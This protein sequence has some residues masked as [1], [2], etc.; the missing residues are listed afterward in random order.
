MQ[1]H[2]KLL[3]ILT[4]WLLCHSFLF[5]QE[6]VLDDK[7]TPPSFK[8]N[9]AE[10]H[11]DYLKNPETNPYQEAFGDELKYIS[12]NNS[13][14]SYLTIGAGYRAR[15]ENFVNQNWTKGDDSYY[16]QRLSIHTNWH[17]S[18]N[19]RIFGE[20]YHGLTTEKKRTLEDEEIDLHQGFMEIFA[21]NKKDNT[22]SL[23][24]GRQELSFGASRLFGIREGPNMRRSFDLARIIRKKGKRTF[25]AF[26][27][28]EV[29]PMFFAF[30]NESNIFGDAQVTNPQT[31]G[32][33]LQ[34]P[35]FVKD[36]QLD[37]YYIGF[38]NQSATFNDVT[39]EE[40]RH[41][42]GL[43][44]SG[45]PSIFSFNTELIYQ[46]GN[47]GGSAIS[48]FN[49]EVDY[50]IRISKGKW[51]PMIGL[52]LDWSSGDVEAGDGKIQTFNPLFVNP[53][54]YSLA[55]V[56]TPANL[57]S[58]HPSFTFFPHPKLY[59]YIEYA[60][61]YRTQQNDGFYSPPRFLTRPAQSNASRH[62]GD[63]FG[64]QMIWSINRN[65]QYQ[66]MSTYFLAADYIEA[67]GPSN[68][69]FYFSTTLNFRI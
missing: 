21:I 61:F 40:T 17:F 4:I 49:F 69:I 58:I 8:T 59:C 43:R 20:W 62:I 56:N 24:L 46:F 67:S 32:L 53:A 33:Y 52:K 18:D 26:Y 41:T 1:A 34:G 15:W 7:P 27:G 9:R 47:I 55:G 51:K 5:A 65:I 42:V 64:L 44:S 12:L 28:R 6:M 13:N 31:W 60:F 11:Y 23:H 36:A 37:F 39:G 50:K 45:T 54:I 22:L 57:T 48:A 29:N 68:N 30:D 2:F 63:T 14:T 35:S 66:L 25:H 16:S 10:E 3:Q 19:I 38:Q